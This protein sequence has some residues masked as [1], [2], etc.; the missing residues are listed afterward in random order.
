MWAL[1]VEKMGCSAFIDVKVEVADVAGSFLYGVDFNWVNEPTF[2]DVRGESVKEPAENVV[3]LAFELFKF[4]LSPL[5]DGL[6]DV[7]DSHDVGGTISQGHL[8]V[9]GP[10]RKLDFSFLMPS[11]FAVTIGDEL[12]AGLSVDIEG[13]QLA[14]RSV[15]GKAPIGMVREVRSIRPGRQ[16][17]FEAT[18][19]IL[20]I[21]LKHLW[22]TAAVLD[23][24]RFNGWIDR[25]EDQPLVKDGDWTRFTLAIFLLGLC[26]FPAFYGPAPELPSCIAERRD[27]FSGFDH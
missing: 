27:I 9:A 6:N 7:A 18:C 24:G 5:L 12:L 4:E 23:A 8:R 13:K 16:M 25:Q 26:Y 14:I 10:N 3:P 22:L 15:R 17:H 11:A 19:R 20:G 2:P 1:K 21:E